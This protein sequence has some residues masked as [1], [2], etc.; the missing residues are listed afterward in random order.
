[1][2]GRRR[3]RTI[4]VRCASVGAVG[5]PRLWVYYDRVGR[6]VAALSYGATAVC[7][8]PNLHSVTTAM[9]C[10]ELDPTFA[11]L[12]DRTLRDQLYRHYD[13]LVLYAVSTVTRSD[14]VRLLESLRLRTVVIFAV[15]TM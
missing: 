15:V 3:Q 6:H 7:A 8:R 1:L 9:F 14:H 2:R 4:S 12:E 13:P 10:V 11:L 5:I